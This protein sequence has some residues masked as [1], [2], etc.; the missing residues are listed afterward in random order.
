MTRVGAWNAVF[1]N[2][3][4]STNSI[5]TRILCIEAITDPA[6][7]L[8]SLSWNFNADGNQYF[9]ERIC[10]KKYMNFSSL[11]TLYRDIRVNAGIK[12]DGM[13]SWNVVDVT[14][15]HRNIRKFGKWK[16]QHYLIIDRVWSLTLHLLWI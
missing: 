3:R 5:Y 15:C 7:T 8:F 12:E 10:N 2:I 13:V 4:A 16:G 11:V 14:S 9:R 1:P 6:F